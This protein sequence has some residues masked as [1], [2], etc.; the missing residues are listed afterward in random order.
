MSI[1]G[2]DFSAQ[3]VIPALQMLAP[4]GI[5][6]TK[7]AHDLLMGTG[8]QESLM[9]TY[10]VQPSGPDIGPYMATPSF[11]VGAVALGNEALYWTPW[12]IVVHLPLRLEELAGRDHRGVADDRDRVA[13]PARLDP[14][15]AKAVLV[16]VECDAVDEAGQDLRMGFWLWRML[17]HM[18]GRRSVVGYLWPPPVSEI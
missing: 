14:Q 5:P 2:F 9:C 7:T 17:L 4:A 18:K 10:R 15:Y 8:A 16:V 13:L 1:L 3:V 6:Y 11:V 12:A